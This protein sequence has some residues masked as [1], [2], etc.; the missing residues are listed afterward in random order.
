MAWSSTCRYLDSHSLHLSGLFVSD[1]KKLNGFKLASRVLRFGA[2]YTLKFA[3]VLLDYNYGK[4]GPSKDIPGFPEHPP[5][6]FS[7]KN[8]KLWVSVNCWFTLE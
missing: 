1:I 5:F 2:S 6:S 8:R 4:R 7:A 3:F